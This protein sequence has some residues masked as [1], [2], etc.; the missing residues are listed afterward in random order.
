MILNKW[1]LNG[2]YVYE[3][4]HIFLFKDFQV[5]FHLNQEW[6]D[7]RLGANEGTNKLAVLGQIWKPKILPANG[8]HRVCENENFVF[9]RGYGDE[10]HVVLNEKLVV[11]LYCTADF[12]NFPFDTQICEMKFSSCKLEILITIL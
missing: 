2:F 8:L 4:I 10:G 3:S 1:W 5:S 12:R 9:W 11:K 6:I 7:P